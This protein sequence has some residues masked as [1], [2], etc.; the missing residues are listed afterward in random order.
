M[1]HFGLNLGQTAEDSEMFHKYLAEFYWVNTCENG[2]HGFPQ[3]N[4]FLYKYYYTFC[5]IWLPGCV[6][7]DRNGYSH[8]ITF[9]IAKKYLSFET[10]CLK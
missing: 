10:Y 5:P 8:E 2:N 7:I 1:S 4:R 3:Q 6:N 9:R